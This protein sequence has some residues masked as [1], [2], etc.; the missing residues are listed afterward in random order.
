MSRT[1]AASRKKTSLPST[2][3]A[4]LWLKW[5]FHL[6]ILLLLIPLGFMPAY[7]K[8]AA[9][10]RGDGGLGERI[11]GD[12][13]IGPWSLTLAEVH[14]D[15]PE[16]DGPAGFV[17]EFNATLCQA[18][19]SQVKAVYMRMG[20]PRSLRAAGAIFEGSPYRLG[21]EVP[22]PTSTQA[23]D[24]LWITLE[25]WDGSVHQKAIPLTQASPQTVQW[26][27]RPGDKR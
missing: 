4:R 10:M 11:M 18:C 19:I 3:L 9:L 8:N 5:R 25:G 14:D 23:D 16:S 12:V 13:Q 1:T 6:N 22:I 15:G 24:E 7:F 21:A 20:K 27:A 26:L 17:K 2:R